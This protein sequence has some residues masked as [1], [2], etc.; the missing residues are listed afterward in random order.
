MSE[1]FVCALFECP[2]TFLSKEA[3]SNIAYFK[4][5][6]SNTRAA[7]QKKGLEGPVPVFLASLAFRG[8]QQGCPFHAFTQCA[9]SMLRGKYP[10]ST[11]PRRA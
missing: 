10:R 3:P 9:R 5:G 7:S 2:C 11:G 8:L 1:G 4:G 6:T